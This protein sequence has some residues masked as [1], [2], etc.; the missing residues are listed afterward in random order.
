MS[1]SG[2]LRVLLVEDDPVHRL[3]LGKYL[4]ALGTHTEVAADGAA[5][6]TLASERHFDVIFMDVE[7][8]VLDG[9]E[10]TR[11]LRA[12]P[13][14]GPFPPR[15]VAITGSAS[16]EDRSRCR[17]AGMDDFLAK[18]VKKAD[19]AAALDRASRAFSAVIVTPRA[20]A[21]TPSASA[22]LLDGA[23]LRSFLASLGDDGIGE[24]METLLANMATLLHALEAAHEAGDR[25]S[26]RRHAHSL[27]SNARMFA[28]GP[29]GEACR[30]IEDTARGEVEGDVGAGVTGLRPLFEQSRAALV[31]EMASPEAR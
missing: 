27:K 18:P 19:L 26:V 22:P 23:T 3:L 30:A 10:A 12:S 28:L 31:R 20:P 6:L 13:L 1:G 16:A 2:A 11:R 7:M 21:A 15:I 8:P 17:E 4:A 24:L 29:L 5:A 25:D 14:P 9:L